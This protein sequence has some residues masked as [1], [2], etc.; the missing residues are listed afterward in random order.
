MDLW[1][2]LTDADL[3]LNITVQKPVQ[4]IEENTHV[5]LS[6]VP[7]LETTRTL[8][9][10][11]TKAKEKVLGKGF[12]LEVKK[13]RND[14]SRLS[15]NPGHEDE[16]ER[17]NIELVRYENIIAASSKTD[18]L[19]LVI[20]ALPIARKAVFKHHLERILRFNGLSSRY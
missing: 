16:L 1:E 13:W 20:V 18:M 15:I 19:D 3:N 2:N 7:Q 12:I 17:K 10:F 4:Y 5:Q 9:K 6:C 14:I 11:N 8:P